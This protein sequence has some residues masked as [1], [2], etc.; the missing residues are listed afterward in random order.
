MALRPVT[1]AR[2][3]KIVVQTSRRSDL[4]IITLF[5]QHAY[6]FGGAALPLIHASFAKCT[7][8]G[9]GSLA[10]LHHNISR[11]SAFPESGH[12]ICLKIDVVRGSF[13]PSP[14]VQQ[15]HCQLRFLPPVQRLLPNE[16]Y[17]CRGNYAPKASP[18]SLA[19]LATK[20]IVW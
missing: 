4:L 6:H 13:R 5:S 1:I 8:G 12:S 16:L 10:D 2:N 3:I 19:V 17:Q 20:L 9:F 15:A 18:S 11:M 7:D 14:V